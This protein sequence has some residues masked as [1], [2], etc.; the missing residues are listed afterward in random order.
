[1][2]N[3]EKNKIKKKPARKNYGPIALTGSGFKGYGLLSWLESEDIFKKVI[4]LDNQKPK[5]S[6]KKTKFYRIDL[7]ETLADVQLAEILQKENIETLIHTAFPVT[8]PHNLAWAHEL[9]SVGS[10]YVCNA[11]SEA[12]IRKLI[13]PSTSDVYGAFPDNPNY[14]SEEHPARGF[15]SSKFIADK[16]DAENQFLKYAK[17]H[18]DSIVTILRPS[19][20]LG[21]TIRSYKTRYL[22]KPLVPTVLGYDPLVQFIHEEDLFGALKKCVLEDHPGIYNLASEGVIPLSKAIRLMGKFSLPLSLLG[23]KTFIQS[24][25]FLGISPAPATHLN[26]LKYM[27][28]IATDKAKNEMGFVPKHSCRDALLD[29][30]GAERLREVRLATS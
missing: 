29:F 1:M 28:V 2:R 14:L 19:N 9:I 6:I 20:I 4:F 21:P 27:C 17:K 25:W 10:M 12:R 15:R 3:N 8:P 22:S 18:P 30:V 13:L 5:L 7:S 24:L 11:A 23:L 26:F 16:I